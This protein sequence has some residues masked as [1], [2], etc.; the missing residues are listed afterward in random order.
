[1]LEPFEYDPGSLKD[2]ELGHMTP[3]FLRA[4]GCD[5]TAFQAILT[6][7]LKPVNW[8]SPTLLT[9]A[10]LKRLRRIVLC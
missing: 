2:K 6:R 8:E 1:M 7:N 5:V 4:W 10:I 9:L 3:Q